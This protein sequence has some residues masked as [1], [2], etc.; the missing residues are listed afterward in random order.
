MCSESLD[1]DSYSRD[2]GECVREKALERALDTRK[3]EIDLYW[4]RASY[5]WT[6]IA[7]TLAGFLAVR[8]SSGP[9]RTDTLILLSCLGLVFSLGWLCV[10]RGSKRWQ[11]NWEYHVD[12]LEDDI[13]GPLFKVLLTR[14]PAATRSERIVELLTGPSPFSVSRINQ[15][16]SIFMTAI[17]V[18]LLVDSLL[19]PRLVDWFPIILVAITVLTCCG[20]FFL[21]RTHTGDHEYRASKRISR[22]GHGA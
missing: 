9:A 21:G 15:M 6:F 18:I 4:K 13:Q 14:L 22:I 17:W 2:F 16:I 3:F 12:M 7:A 19:P 1:G 11:E 8:T 10:N 5:F 20:F